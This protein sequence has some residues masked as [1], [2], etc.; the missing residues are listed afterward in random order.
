MNASIEME[1]RVGAEYPP[2]ELTHELYDQLRRIA[3]RH[4]GNERRNHTLQPT[5]LVHEAY[6]K[7]NGVRE[8]TFNDE[9]HFLAVASRVM[10]QVLLDHAR[11]RSTLKRSGGRVQEASY[12]TVLEMKQDGGPE[13]VDLIQL[14]DALAALAAENETLS[15][16]VEMRY[17]GGLTAEETAEALGISVHA[18][19]HNLRFAQ[20]WL[21]RK[22]KS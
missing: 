1:L 3:D 11:S 9:V 19:R 17:F 2:A 14:D 7:L 13:I 21:R 8:K 15:R 18:V 6:L 12:K 16:I 10:R 4:M 20:A 22:L 5:A